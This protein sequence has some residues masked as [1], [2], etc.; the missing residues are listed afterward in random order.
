[1]T[2]AQTMALWADRLR[3]ISAGGLLFNQNLHDRENYQKIQAI[4]L[5]ML[6]LATGEPL[7]RLEPLQ[8][9]VFG[10]P[11]PL[12]VGDAAIIEESGK[13]LLVQR[14]DNRK[15]AMPGG[16]LAVGETPAEG[17]V[18]E[19]LEETGVH[20]EPVALVGVYDSRRCGT[21]SRFHLYQFVFL[22]RPLEGGEVVQPPSHTHE[23]L[24]TAWFAEDALPEDLDPGHVT[25]IP[26]AFRVWRGDGRVFFDR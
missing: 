12:A 8:E 15:W 17:V 14:A 7:E 18:R 22:C 24:D 9:S 19:A 16:A 23:V 6:A 21:V 3:D 1:V 26:D 11:T 20:C 13:I 5:E 4:A 10:R 25:R 2:L